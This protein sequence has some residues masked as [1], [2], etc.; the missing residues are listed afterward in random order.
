MTLCVL[1]ANMIKVSILP[2]TRDGERNHQDNMST[3]GYFGHPANVEANRTP[4]VNPEADKW[5]EVAQLTS[6]IIVTEH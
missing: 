1:C 3:N 5:K 2:M 6:A 4:G